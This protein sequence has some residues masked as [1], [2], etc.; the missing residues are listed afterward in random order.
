MLE[1]LAGPVI[2]MEGLA[3][4]SKRML[5]GVAKAKW[6]GWEF[7]KLAACI[8]KTQLR[9]ITRPHSSQKVCGIITWDRSSNQTITNFPGKRD[10]ELGA[11]WFTQFRS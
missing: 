8:F 6:V 5:H 2:S 3:L 1:L 9:V 4:W 7:L 11:L 10:I